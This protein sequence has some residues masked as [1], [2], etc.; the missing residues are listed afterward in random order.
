MNTLR[1]AVWVLAMLPMATIARA[2][3]PMVIGLW[4]AGGPSWLLSDLGEGFETGYCMDF[5]LTSR[6]GRV[7][8]ELFFDGQSYQ[9][10][11]QR[12]AEASAKNGQ[13]TKVS[14]S[15]GAGGLR[16][17]YF[18]P[19]PGS[20]VSVYGD[21]G[22]GLHFSGATEEVGDERKDDPTTFGFEGSVGTGVSFDVSPR[23]SFVLGGRY[24][25]A[26]TNERPLSSVG[27]TAGL[28]LWFR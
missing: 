6:Q 13:P 16:I 2:E 25:Q 7:G 24:H 18:Y 23:W 4:V 22:A 28:T 17:R 11:S 14:Y 8:V 12:N 26:V 19:G 3:E 5:A 27:A 20:P 21:A 10:T 9:A 1:S 15:G